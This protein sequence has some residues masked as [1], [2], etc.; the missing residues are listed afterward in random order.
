MV[1]D[2]ARVVTVAVVGGVVV[3]VAADERA[4]FQILKNQNDGSVIGADS[5]PKTCR[6]ISFINRIIHDTYHKIRFHSQHLLS[7][8]TVEIHERHINANIPLSKVT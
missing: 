6:M 4:G 2:G 5:G 8:R 3:F 1:V 7:K